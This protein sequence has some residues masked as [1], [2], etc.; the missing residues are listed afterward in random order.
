MSEHTAEE[1]PEDFKVMRRYDAEWS[2][3]RLISWGAVF[4]AIA[5]AVIYALASVGGN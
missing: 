1:L 5:I 4:L 3:P 2:G